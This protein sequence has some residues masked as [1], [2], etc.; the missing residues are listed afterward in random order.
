[1]GGWDFITA[2]QEH[3]DYTKDLCRRLCGQELGP[4]HLQALSLSHEG[5]V[6]HWDPDQGGAFPVPRDSPSVNEGSSHARTG[7]WGAGWV[8]LGWAG[9]HGLF[10]SGHSPWTRVSQFEDP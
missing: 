10:C 1:M 6:E 5:L 4:G 2:F 7:S 9:R 3:S 8:K